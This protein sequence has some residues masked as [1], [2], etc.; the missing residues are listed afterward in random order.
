[1]PTV[2]ITKQ[3]QMVDAVCQQHYGRTAEVTEAVLL[4]NPGMAD[5]GPILPIGTR[6]TM[7]DISAKQSAP[8]LPTLWD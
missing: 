1:M 7:P 4:A 2:L 8:S 3:G 6:V 5:L